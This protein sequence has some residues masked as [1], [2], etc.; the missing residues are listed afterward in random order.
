LSRTSSTRSAA[1]RSSIV[2]MS[3]RAPSA[4]TPSDSAAAATT[5]SGVR[6]SASGTKKTPS[7]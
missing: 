4:R 7:A 1:S 3:G 2:S 5:C 6:A